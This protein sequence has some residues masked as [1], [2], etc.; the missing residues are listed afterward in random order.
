MP[1]PTAKGK[2]AETKR[3]VSKLAKELKLSPEEENEI[4]EAFE[5]FVDED[6]VTDAIQTT[7]VRKAML[8]V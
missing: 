5:M 3:R 1:P 6:E 2:A 4:R 8:Y 7:D